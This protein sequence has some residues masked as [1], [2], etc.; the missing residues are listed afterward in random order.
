MNVFTRGYQ[1]TKKQL[2]LP[3]PLMN[4]YP[5]QSRQGLRWEFNSIFSLHFEASRPKNSPECLHPSKVTVLRAQTT[6]LRQGKLG[7]FHLTKNFALQEKGSKRW[8]ITSVNGRGE[9]RSQRS[10]AFWARFI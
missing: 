5:L 10:A 3:L 7:P 1:T 9:I 8:E 2:T 4:D 6:P